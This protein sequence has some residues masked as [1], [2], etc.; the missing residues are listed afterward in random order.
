MSGKVRDPEAVGVQR[1]ST[2]QLLVKVSNIFSISTAGSSV[3]SLLTL[4]NSQV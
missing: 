2:N 4:I 3:M 1:D